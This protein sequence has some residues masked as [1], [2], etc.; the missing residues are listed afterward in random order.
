M[1][2][3]RKNKI[4]KKEG[5]GETVRKIEKVKQGHMSPKTDSHSGTQSF[6]HSPPDI[7]HPHRHILSHRHR[8][9][10]HHTHLSGTTQRETRDHLQPHADMGSK[11]NLRVLAGRDLP[12]C[13]D[14]VL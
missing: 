8:S 7:Q 2:E 14:V 9:L 10:G 11:G 5:R 1:R 4:Q 6:C 13:L 3:R 12:V